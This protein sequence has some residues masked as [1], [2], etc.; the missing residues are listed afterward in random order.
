MGI[1]SAHIGLQLN[2]GNHLIDGQLVKDPDEFIWDVE[3]ENAPFQEKA[4]GFLW[5][6]DLAANGS[7][8][9]VAKAR[10]WFLE[11]VERF[12]DGDNSAWTP[13]LAGGRVI[14]MVNHAIVLLGNS[15]EL[16]AEHYFETISHHA[17]FLKKRSQ[18]AP[19]GL[20]KFQ[21]L[22]GYVYSTLALEEFA[23]DLKRAMRAL[24][25][26][27]E[28][29]VAPDGGVPTRSPEEL[30]EIF[31]L[32]VW[33]EQGMTSASFQPDRVLLDTI[34][35][36]SPAIRSLRIGDGRLV[37]FQG[38][39][40]V[41]SVIVEQALSDAGT[42]L[43]TTQE[44]VMGYARASAKNI[45]L[46]M[47]TG[48]GASN[49]A[50]ALAFE[51][52]VDDQHI[53]QSTGF[54]HGLAPSSYSV[55]V[56]EDTKFSASRMQV[57]SMTE[58]QPK[59]GVTILG[60][61]HTRY[62]EA[63]GLTY[64]RKLELDENGRILFGSENFKCTTAKDKAVFDKTMIG[65]ENNLREYLLRFHVAPDVDV[66][67]DLG[68]TAVSLRLPNNDVWIFKASSGVLTLKDSTYFEPDRIKPRATKQIVVSSDIVNYEGAVTWMLTRLVQ[69]RKNPY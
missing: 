21:A 43:G 15:D 13:E 11:W 67:L 38:G 9:C 50:S 60:A 56:I 54:C 39:K 2:A 45:V 66:E 64:S 63:Y 5:L 30:L 10:Q 22:A 42:R 7:Q 12:G 29:Y 18:F 36:M 57:F 51:V 4:H 35:R 58:I 27:C 1:G 17:R 24:A 25:K 14:R 59:A 40:A 61:A 55:A 32:L 23:S 69:E 19:E 6:D 37:A 65:Q 62:K 44:R 26:E 52:S 47:D 46:I 48:V 31:R 3:Y 34:E 20:P 28:T 68:G 41:A 16:D 53:F 8:E 49:S 33:I